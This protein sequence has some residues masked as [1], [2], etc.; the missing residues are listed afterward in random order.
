MNKTSNIIRWV[1]FGVLTLIT[2]V[3]TVWYYLGLGGVLNGI[4]EPTWQQLTDQGQTSLTL[5]DFI[6]DRVASMNL[7]FGY[8]LIILGVV[9]AL[10][11]AVFAIIIGIIKGVEMNKVISICVVAG[12]LIVLAII[13]SVVSKDRVDAQLNFFYLTFGFSILAILFSIV[14]KVVKK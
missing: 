9:I 5:K 6:V 14:Y 10:I 8:I 12:L 2:L 4:Y 1:V 7:N 13:A 3:V 11:A